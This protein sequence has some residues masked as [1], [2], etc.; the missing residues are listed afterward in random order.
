MAF[1]WFKTS[2]RSIYGQS[3]ILLV[4]FTIDSIAYGHG[5]GNA[6]RPVVVFTLKRK[7]NL[8]AFPCIISYQ[9]KFR[10]IRS[11]GNRVT[12]TQ[13]ALYKHIKTAVIYNKWPI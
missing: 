9:R 10:E 7:Q 3:W 8:I 13:S 11:N 5:V 6:R 2:I 4:T 12:G 1:G